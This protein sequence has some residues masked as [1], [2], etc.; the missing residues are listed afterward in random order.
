MG[1]KIGGAY[2]QKH[3]IYTMFWHSFWADVLTVLR[4]LRCWAVFVRLVE[5]DAWK[6]SRKWVVNQQNGWKFGV[7]ILSTRLHWRQEIW[8]WPYSQALSSR[9]PRALRMNCLAVETSP[10]FWQ[11]GRF[12]KPGQGKSSSMPQRNIMP[13]WRPGTWNTMWSK[14]GLTSGFG[15]LSHSQNMAAMVI[16]GTTAASAARV[17]LAMARNYQLLNNLSYEDNSKQ[18]EMVQKDEKTA[19]CSHRSLAGASGQEDVQLMNQNDRC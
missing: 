4:D 3:H 5:L 8:V 16:N 9:M 2:H 14:N 15:S 11:N 6:Y 10:K 19:R 12:K 1:T 7:R 13:S 18:R 17:C